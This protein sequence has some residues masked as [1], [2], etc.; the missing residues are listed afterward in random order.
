[1][2]SSLFVSLPSKYPTPAMLYLYKIQTRT[3][4]E[5]CCLLLTFLSPESIIF[6]PTSTFPTNKC[7]KPLAI[8]LLFPWQML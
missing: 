3:K 6:H 2:A 8:L 5:Y 1:M 7:C 4:M